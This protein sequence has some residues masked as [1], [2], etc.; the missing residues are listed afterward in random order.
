[1]FSFKRKIGNQAED[2]ALAYLS[3]QRLK[4]IEKNYLTLLGEIDIIMLDKISQTLVFI[5]VRYRAN[6]RFGTAIET[7]TH[8]KQANIIRTAELYLQRHQ[9][10][11]DYLCRFDV[12]GLES[13]LKYPKIN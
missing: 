1:M 7:V 8:K 6:I 13:D 3:K 10:Y 11:Q 9:K 12:I 5:E 4:L 2:I